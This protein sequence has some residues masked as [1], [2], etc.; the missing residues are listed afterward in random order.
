MQQPSPSFPLLSYLDDVSISFVQVHIRRFTAEEMLVE[1]EAV[2][3]SLRNSFECRSLKSCVIITFLNFRK[4]ILRT[5]FDGSPPSEEIRPLVRALARSRKIAIAN[6][7]VR[8]AR[9]FL[10]LRTAR[11]LVP[12]YTKLGLSVSSSVTNG[13]VSVVPRFSTTV[14]R[15]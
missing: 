3:R 8:R 4:V 15:L 2:S 12:F 14:T 10:L 5:R 11:A 9:V 6:A 7:S 13:P 1:A